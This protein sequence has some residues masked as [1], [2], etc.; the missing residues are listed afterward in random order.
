MYRVRDRSAHDEDE[1]GG[2][3]VHQIRGEPEEMRTHVLGFDH[4]D[5]NQLNLLAVACLLQPEIF[6]SRLRR[7]DPAPPLS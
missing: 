4:Y 2:G 5:N 1:D 7:L 3:E 6:Y